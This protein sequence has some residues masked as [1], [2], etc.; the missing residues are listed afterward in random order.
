M[1]VE[2]E[3]LVRQCKA[4]FEKYVLEESQKFLDKNFNFFERE[5][6]KALKNIIQES[7]NKFW[8]LPMTEEEIKHYKEKGIDLSS[9][10]V[11]SIEIE[12]EMTWYLNIKFD[13]DDSTH[14]Y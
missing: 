11:K 7:L 13:G 9:K 2:C 12:N 10:L 4:K 3:K 8:E 1:K 14:Y 6:T 5:Q